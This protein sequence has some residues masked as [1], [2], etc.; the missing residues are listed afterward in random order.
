MTPQVEMA[1]GTKI[2]MIVQQRGRAVR[3]AATYVEPLGPRSDLSVVEIDR[4]AHPRIRQSR[5]YLRADQIES[6]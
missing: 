1:K 6:R 3:Y 2:W 4:E 5:R